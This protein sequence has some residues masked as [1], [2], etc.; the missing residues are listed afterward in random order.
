MKALVVSWG[1]WIS[2]V[3]AGNE[4]QL[5]D[6]PMVRF[7]TEGATRNSYL[8]FMKDLYIALT[9]G[10]DRS[11]EI[12]ILP[13]AL[14]QYVQVRLS[15]G[16]QVIDFILD[17]SNANI[18]GYLPGGNGRSYFFSDVPDDVRNDL[19]PQTIRARLLFNGS[20]EALEAV[21]GVD[22]REIPLGIGE[23]SRHV[24]YLRHL[25]PLRLSNHPAIAR[26]L[27][28]CIE[29]V[30]EAVR[31]RYIQQQILAELQLQIPLRLELMGCFIQMI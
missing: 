26:S 11:G 2:M 12:P 25:T 23:L 22:R 17:V 5:R 8:N 20:Y 19:F 31:L 15:N 21:A 30:S 9:D 16:A 6:V 18:L 27:V 10:A 28:V 1:C 3:A 14:Q 13:P 4:H 24:Y 29:M 7:T